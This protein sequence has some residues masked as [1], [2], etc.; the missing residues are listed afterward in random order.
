[1]TAAGD[2]GADR[3]EMRVA[4]PPAGFAGLDEPPWPEQ[5]FGVSNT[6]LIDDSPFVKCRC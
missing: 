4:Q 5:K 6:S 2:I 3:G 1:V